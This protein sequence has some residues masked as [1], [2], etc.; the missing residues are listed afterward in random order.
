MRIGKP[1]TCISLCLSSDSV[2]KIGAKQYI[3]KLFSPIGII[4][5]N[6]IYNLLRS[7][8]YPQL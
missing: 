1:M 2:Y 4:L 8:D 7:F 5:I 6:L 3:L